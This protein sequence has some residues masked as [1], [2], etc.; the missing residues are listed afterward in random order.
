MPIITIR[1]QLGSGAPEIGKEVARRLDIDYVDREIIAD[2]ASRLKWTKES[3]TDK[4]MPPGTLM[5]RIAEALSYSPI[6]GGG[7]PGAYLPT[8]DFPLT[9]TKYIAGLE[10]V[11]KELAKSRNIVIRGRGSQF[12]LR[13]ILEAVHILVI[14]P[15]ELRIKRVMSD[16][17]L[18]DSSAK[19][20]IDRFDSS[21]REFIKRYF[22]AELEDPHHYDLVINT[23]HLNINDSATIIIQLLSC[24]NKNSVY[25]LLT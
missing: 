18:D 21:R 13:G 24:K 20:E 1:G 5:G 7:Y 22:N 19:K 4:E 14:T 16:L 10:S 3:I 8:W 17:N 23:A 6:I 11:I 12:I 2:V 9:D 25:K 15:L